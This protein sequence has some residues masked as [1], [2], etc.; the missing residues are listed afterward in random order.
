VHRVLPLPDVLETSVPPLHVMIVTHFRQL[1]NYP[2]TGVEEVS[3]QFVAALGRL[4][5]IR[6]LR[7]MD[8]VE[9]Q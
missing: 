1:G 6:K 9:I 2:Q 4:T 7:R 5:R 3:E 8:V